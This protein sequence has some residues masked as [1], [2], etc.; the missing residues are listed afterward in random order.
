LADGFARLSAT[1]RWMRFL[2]PKPELS[3]AELRYLTE[4]DHHNHEALGALDNVSGRGVGVARYVRST[5]DPEVAE[6]AVTIV[7][8]WQGRGLGTELV[9]QLSERACEE[10]IRRFTGL[11]AASNVA[12]AGLARSMGADVVLSEHATVTY[13]VPLVR[14][15]EPPGSTEPPAN[16]EAGQLA[17]ARSTCA[18][19]CQAGALPA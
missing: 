10:G 7:D 8:A 1:P 11:A 13:E 15:E 5:V 17:P 3:A 19:S 2:A 6:V 18:V 16:T 14:A 4:I 12:V 9:A